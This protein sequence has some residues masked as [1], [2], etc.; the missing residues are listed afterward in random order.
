[1]AHVSCKKIVK[2]EIVKPEIEVVRYH[3]CVK[4][5][6]YFDGGRPDYIPHRLAAHGYPRHMRSEFVEIYAHE[7]STKYAVKIIF[8]QSV[9]IR[10]AFLSFVQEKVLWCRATN[11]PPGTKFTPAEQQYQLINSPSVWFVPDDE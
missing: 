2:K 11:T 4:C 8:F 3:L 1:M 5:D 6:L 10:C 9:N 7:L